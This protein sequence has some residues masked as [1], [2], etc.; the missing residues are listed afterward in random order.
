MRAP[1][2]FPQPLKSGARVMV[3]RPRHGD[4]VLFE[5]CRCASATKA[6]EIA[7][8]LNATDA[9]KRSVLPLAMP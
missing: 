1:R 9:V 8:A 5:I 3:N 6:D 7:Q 2:Y 4:D